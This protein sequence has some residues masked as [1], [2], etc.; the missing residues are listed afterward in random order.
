MK[1]AAFDADLPPRTAIPAL[2]GI[3]YDHSAATACDSGHPI[4]DN[5]PR[6]K[7]KDVCV[8]RPIETDRSLTGRHAYVRLK[9]DR[10]LCEFVRICAKVC[11]SFT[12]ALALI[13]GH[14]R[15]IKINQ[16]FLKKFDIPSVHKCLISG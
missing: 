1:S 9:I 2:S 15:N 10:N 16:N 14:P 12:L 8:Q 13:T 7:W 4:P 6:P 11:A 3:E 5:G